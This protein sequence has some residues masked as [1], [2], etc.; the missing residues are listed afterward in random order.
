MDLFT[1]QR[2]DSIALAEGACWLPGFALPEMPVLW[3]CIKHHLAAHPPQRMMTPMGYLMSVQTSSMGN[4]GWVSDT[5]GYGYSATDPQSGESWP[6][7]PAVIL[8]LAEDAAKKA[9]YAHFVPDS[10]LVNVYA[11]GS[12]MG[13]HQDK[14][15]KDFTQ[16]IVSVSLGLPATFLFGGSKRSDKPVKI[17][18]QHGD[19]VVWGGASRRF[20]HGIA[21]IRAGTHSLT[22]NCRINLTLRKAG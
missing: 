5:Q 20:Y 6:P 18:L 3:S 21:T 15:E 14:D 13:L 2:P 7:L 4:L 12:K 16:P 17:P 9:G 11:P 1:E 10:C 8:K 19:V 22:G